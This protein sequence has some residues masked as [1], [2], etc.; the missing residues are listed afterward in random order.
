MQYLKIEW[1][2]FFGFKTRSNIQVFSRD[3]LHC[4]EER[5]EIKEGHE[6]ISYDFP[7][8]VTGVEKVMDSFWPILQ[9]S[10]G[11]AKIL[12]ENP[13]IVYRSLEI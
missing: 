10:D 13:K 7:S 11:T 6:F 1:E 5:K 12:N 9:A 8:S 2:C 4:Q 3:S